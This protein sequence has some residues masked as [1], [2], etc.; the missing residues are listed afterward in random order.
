MGLSETWLSDTITDPEI[1]P[2]GYS[3][4]RKNRGS[5]G[6]GVLLA[7]DNKLPCRQIPCPENLEMVVVSISFS[8]SDITIYR[9]YV[10]PNSFAE[11]HIILS[12]A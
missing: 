4:Y 11:H 2:Q 5:Q 8:D 3:N 1:L 10:P 6:G 12:I 9:T 7:I